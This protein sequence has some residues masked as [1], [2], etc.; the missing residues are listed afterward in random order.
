MRNRSSEC[1]T[2][3]KDQT[4]NQISMREKQE[5]LSCVNISNLRL[6]RQLGKGTTKQVY[7]STYQGK[8]VAVKMITPKVDDVQAC[9]QR[10][11]YAKPEECYLYANYKLLKELTLS[12][13]LSHRNILKVRCQ[14]NW[15]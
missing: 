9:L 11:K 14:L 6:G 12:M 10:G 8:E 3:K 5:L 15:K 1:K 4:Q 7:L 13:Q 2:E